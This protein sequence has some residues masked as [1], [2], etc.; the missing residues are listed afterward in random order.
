MSVSSSGAEPANKLRRRPNRLDKL[1][2]KSAKRG[3]FAYFA[4]KLALMERSGTLGKGVGA[5]SL[6]DPLPLLQSGSQLVSNTQSFAVLQPELIPL[7]LRRLTAKRTCVLT[8]YRFL[9]NDLTGESVFFFPMKNVQTP[10]RCFG[11]AAVP[12]CLAKTVP[13]IP[14]GRL[15]FRSFGLLRNTRQ[16]H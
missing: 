1:G 5:R 2:L 7:R 10:E 3:R 4:P 15:I 13:R 14:S 9:R 6:A 11:D 16:V 12:Y 8:T